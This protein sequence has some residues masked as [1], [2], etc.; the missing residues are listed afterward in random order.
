VN[1]IQRIRKEMGDTQDSL[2]HSALNDV[3]EF[4]DEFSRACVPGISSTFACEC[5]KCQICYMKGIFEKLNKEIS[6]KKVNRVKIDAK[7]GTMGVCCEEKDC[8]H[9]YSCAQH[10]SAGD[11][12]SEDGM[13]PDLI[14]EQ[15]VPYCSKQ[16]TKRNFG[17]LGFVHDEGEK[18]SCVHDR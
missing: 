7:V 13:T 4:F 3:V 5:G 15:G 12:R 11:F 8:M 17:E 10:G 14:V 16:N 9:M 6:E 18:L 2:L 1:R